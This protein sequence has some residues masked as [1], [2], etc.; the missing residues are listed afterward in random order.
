MRGKMHAAHEPL[1]R[2][3]HFKPDT[4]IAAVSASAAAV[5]AAAAIA[6]EAVATFA[7]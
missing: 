5:I 3:P 4:G 2:R 7:L 6:P 1:A